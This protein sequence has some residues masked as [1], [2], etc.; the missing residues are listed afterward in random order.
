MQQSPVKTAVI[1]AAGR[2][3]RLE[4]K[5]ENLPK[6]LLEIN[7]LSLLQR[8]LQ[9]L[10]DAQI[11]ECVLVIGYQY[12]EIKKTFGPEYQGLK[13]TYVMN[14]EWET[15]NNLVSLHKAVPFIKTDFI[16]LE[17][18]LVFSREAILPFLQTNCLGLDN[19]LPFMEGTLVAVNSNNQVSHFYLS[20]D[21]DY[22][23]DPRDFLK[24]VNIYSFS[25][26][27]FESV[28]VPEIEK[29][30]ANGQRNEYYERAFANAVKNFKLKIQPVLFKKYKWAEIDTLKDFFYAEQLFR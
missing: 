19:F 10:A 9:A 16:L 18:D 29:L 28:I 13:L 22:P 17:S 25:I 8:A 6:C 27:D 14:E 4:H 24:T 20:K 12:Q 15:S 3:S 30:L 23:K 2:G 21:A 1:L 26:K 5:T 7:G 11:Q